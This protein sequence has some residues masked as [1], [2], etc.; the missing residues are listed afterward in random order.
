MNSHIM[1]IL[2][3]L[4]NSRRLPP[5]VRAAGRGAVRRRDQRARALLRRDDAAGAP[6]RRVLHLV[7]LRAALR[8]RELH[9]L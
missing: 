4:M 5:G 6:H 1:R 8:A 9:L 2:M 7:V 3:M